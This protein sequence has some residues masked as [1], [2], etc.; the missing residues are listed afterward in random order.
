MLLESCSSM[1]N[2]KSHRL[3]RH[4]KVQDYVEW[5]KWMKYLFVQGSKESTLV[6]RSR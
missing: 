3:G 5:I 6:R 2:S 4:L 1:K